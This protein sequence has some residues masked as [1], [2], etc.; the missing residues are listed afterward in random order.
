MCS[1]ECKALCSRRAVSS[2]RARVSHGVSLGNSVVRRERR[3]CERRSRKGMPFVASRRESPCRAF[4]VCTSCACRGVSVLGNRKERRSY[5]AT[6]R[7]TTRRVG[8]A[9]RAAPAGAR[10]PP[11]SSAAPSRSRAR[12]ERPRQPGEAILGR[13]ER[14]SEER[15]ERERERRRTFQT[16][17][18]QKKT[19]PSS[20]NSKNNRRRCSIALI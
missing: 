20:G 2:C 11:R 6:T 19:D 8:P 9:R 15:R 10:P 5:V 16:E 13:A 17:S 14:D 12:R 3:S 4:A 18:T 7:S 1:V